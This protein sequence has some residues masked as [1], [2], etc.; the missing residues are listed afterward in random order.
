VI[1]LGDDKVRAALEN[2]IENQTADV[3]NHPDPAS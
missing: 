2:H 3:L 1:A